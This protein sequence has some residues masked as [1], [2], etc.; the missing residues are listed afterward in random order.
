VSSAPSC[1]YRG[2]NIET[3]YGVVNPE[4]RR[5]QAETSKARRKQAELTRASKHWRHPKPSRDAEALPS[6]SVKRRARKH[7]VVPSKAV[8]ILSAAVVILRKAAVI[9]S[10]A[11]DLSSALAPAQE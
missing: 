1:A 6:T 3:W 5:K 9:L 4:A 10:E 7:P 2:R 8:V 11:K